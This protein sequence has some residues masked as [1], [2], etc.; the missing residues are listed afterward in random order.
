[1]NVKNYI[2]EVLV[3]V[4]I[5]GILVRAIASVIRHVQ[6]MGIQILKFVQARYA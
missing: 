3:K 4:V 6:L 1:M 5:S 2:V